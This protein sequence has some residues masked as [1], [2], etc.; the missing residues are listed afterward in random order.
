MLGGG[1]WAKMKKWR[2]D[3]NSQ[4]TL[5]KYKEG[6]SSQIGEIWLSAIPPPFCNGVL[7]RLITVVAP[8]GYPVSRKMIRHN[9]S[10]PFI[11]SRICILS[12]GFV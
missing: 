11:S 2:S 9:F 6:D 4:D 7:I 12:I 1:R 3:A 10:R 5:K 8:Y